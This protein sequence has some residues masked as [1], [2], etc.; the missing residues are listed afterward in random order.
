M[1]S[2]NINCRFV[3]FCVALLFL[4]QVI[5]FDSSFLSL[6]LFSCIL[7]GD[8]VR[9]TRRFLSWLSQLCLF[10]MHNFSIDESSPKKNHKESFAGGIGEGVMKIKP[11]NGN[12]NP[13]LLHILNQEQFWDPPRWVYYFDV[14]FLKKKTPNT[15]KQAML[16]QFI[17]EKTLQLL[18]WL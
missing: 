3:I 13:F 12:S 2:R 17:R 11:T 15:K 10:N 18:R 16:P 6:L 14:F 7:N 8:F 9:L 4:L 1:A 5:D